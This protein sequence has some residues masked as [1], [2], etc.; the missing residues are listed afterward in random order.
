[1]SAKHRRR[2]WL[3]GG[4]V[5]IAALAGGLIAVELATRVP[6]NYAE[7]EPGLFVG[8][9][10]PDPPQGTAAVLNLCES[11]DP[12]RADCHEWHPIHDASPAPSLEWLR[13]R[14]EFIHAHLA[15]GHVVYVHCRNGVSRSVMVVTA[16]LMKANRSTASDAL[17]A[18]KAKRDLARPNPAFRDLLRE[19]EVEL[20]GHRE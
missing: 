13:D 14:V 15:A 9:L 1:M 12:Y 18:V 5:S 11:D 17:A 4:V 19:W 3:V 7:V 6:P 20:A 8:G 2:L 16:Y 10:V